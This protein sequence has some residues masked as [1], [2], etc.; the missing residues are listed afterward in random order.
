MTTPLTA[1][2]P[3]RQETASPVSPVPQVPPPV[4][5]VPLASP[6]FLEKLLTYIRDQP[7]SVVQLYAVG[8]IG[9][10]CII[11]YGVMIL[12]LLFR[13]RLNQVPDSEY[14]DLS[15]KDE[16]MMVV[17]IMNMN[18]MAASLP[19]PWLVYITAFSCVLV[20][21]AYFILLI[22]MLYN[23]SAKGYDTYKGLNNNMNRLQKVRSTLEDLDTSLEDIEPIYYDGGES[24][25]QDD[26]KTVQSMLDESAQIESK[27]NA[28][29]FRAN[30]EVFKEPLPDDNNPNES[31]AA[32]LNKLEGTSM[33]AIVRR[34]KKAK[35]A[36][37]KR[38]GGILGAI[39]IKKTEEK[40]A[41]ARKK[42]G[43]AEKK[44][45]EAEREQERVP[46]LGKA[47]PTSGGAITA[48]NAGR[49]TPN[50]ALLLPFL[51]IGLVFLITGIYSIVSFVTTVQK[52]RKASKDAAYEKIIKENIPRNFEFLDGLKD[53][54]M[55]ST[56]INPYNWP[57]RVIN[58]SFDPDNDSD[59]DEIVKMMFMYRLASH[60]VTNIAMLEGTSKTYAANAVAK[61]ANQLSA[62]GDNM[63]DFIGIMATTYVTDMAPLRRFKADRKYGDVAALTEM[64]RCPRDKCPVGKLSFA[65][66]YRK[67]AND[68]DTKL[69]RISFRLANIVDSADYSQRI[70][71]QYKL[72]S[73][74][75]D[76][77][78]TMHVY[79]PLSILLVMALYC[80]IILEKSRTRTASVVMLLVMS[81]LP[82]IIQVF[83]DWKE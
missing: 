67:R 53:F 11:Q 31:I 72:A 32:E 23:K 29:I 57:P 47:G 17:R 66:I 13:K 83:V 20:L 33:E 51:G 58:I 35:D 2:I 21:A 30:D 49:F 36:K 68:I 77:F 65:D 34:V 6:G 7:W 63:G 78:S 24:A 74:F 75:L 70:N 48:P 1:T 12:N 5:L 41:E 10:G 61:R 18:P 8:L 60:Y 54:V 43:E 39:G 69:D 37:W 22:K 62:I 26:K 38:N 3:T 19:Y 27:I 28:G 55:G 14:E 81:I 9:V 50:Y 16:T 80:R 42:E 76:M 44:E 45:A 56:K 82:F 79:V 64:L 40:K 59:I 52:V 73:D 25:L 46:L 15:R 4:P 71:T